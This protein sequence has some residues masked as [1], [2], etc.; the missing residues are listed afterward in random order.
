MSKNSCIIYTAI[1]HYGGYPSR[2]RDITKAIIETK[3]NEWD[4]KIIPCSWGI[5]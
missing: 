1:D 2:G 5:S 3:Q 4:I